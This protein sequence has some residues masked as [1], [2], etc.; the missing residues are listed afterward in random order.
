MAHSED[1]RERVAA[2]LSKTAEGRKRLDAVEERM[3]KWR[4]KQESQAATQRRREQRQDR[5][6]T[7]P[8]GSGDER[9]LGKSRPFAT[10][11]EDEPNASAEENSVNDDDIV[12][13]SPDDDPDDAGR[14]AHPLRRVSVS[15]SVE[16]LRAAWAIGP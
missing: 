6:A 4:V 10:E 14:A 13:S 7:T 15:A 8:V 1:C 5:E 12:I 3:E 9:E 11:N 16:P 2:E